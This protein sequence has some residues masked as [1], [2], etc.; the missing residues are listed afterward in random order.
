VSTTFASP[1]DRKCQVTTTQYFR[2]FARFWRLIV[3]CVV[4]GLFIPLVIG[5]LTSSTYVS[6]TSVLVAGTS[7][8]QTGAADAYQSTILAQQRMATYADIAQGPTLAKRINDELDTKLSVHDLEH[9]IDVTVPE[10]SSI[11]R[12]DVTDTDRDRARV[13]ASQAATAMVEVVKDLES[14]RGRTFSLL[15]ARVV[16]DAST[17]TRVSEPPVWRNAALGAAAGLVLGLALAVALS[18]L[19]PRLTDVTAVQEALEAPVLGV[20]PV[21]GRRKSRVGAAADTQGWDAAIRELRTNIFFRHPGPDRC[22]VLAITSPHPVDQLPRIGGAVAAALI[23]TGSR[24]L[25]VDADL[26]EPRE[27]PVFDQYAEQPAGL[28]SY[29]EGTSTEEEVIR[30]DEDFGIDV[31]PA[32]VHLAN[33]ADLLHTQP[34]ATLLESAAKRYDFVL[35]MTPALSVGTDALAVAARCDGTLLTIRSRRTTLAQVT[36]ARR[37]LDRLNAE[38]IGAVLLT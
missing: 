19:D 23:D 3:L 17:P 24:V 11:L 29:L 36:S 13:L 33:P 6:S 5:L 34:F 20:L 38:L 15:R 2:A 9:R 22:L 16:A 1:A 37:Q 10:G 35:V 14:V 12:I 26:H 32:G 8:A 28:S 25:L 4:L 7:T 27:A 18:R 21:S 31:V 30:Q